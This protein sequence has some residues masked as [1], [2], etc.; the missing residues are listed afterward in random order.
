M[1]KLMLLYFAVLGFGNC[2]NAPA[3][4][5]P[6]AAVTTVIDTM[7][8]F[9]PYELD[10]P[11]QTL[12]LD[13]DL[14]EVSGLGMMPGDQQFVAVEDENGTIYTVDVVTGELLRKVDFHKA[15][16]YEGV[17]WVNGNVW[18]VKSTGTLYQVQ[19]FGTEAQQMVKHPN[20][21][22]RAYDVEGLGYD[23]ARHRLLLS[24]KG[25]GG[26]GVENIYRKSI[27]QFDL[28]TNTLDTVPAYSIELE[29]VQDYLNERPAIRKLTKLTE[30][31]SPG[32][33]EFGFCPSGL[34]VHPI[35]DELYILSSSGKLL[36]VVSK[37][38]AIRHIEKLDKDIHRQPEGICFS[39]E[40]TLY[41]SNEGKGSVEP[42]IHRFNFQERF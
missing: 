22:S 33:S 23:A 4:A 42:L 13:N 36:I 40:G 11:D 21:L 1:L 14:E 24:C 9:F 38:G 16:D 25:V 28:G 15:G 32:C 19:N 12:T 27:Y 29:A 20:F 31:F 18:V 35:T 37:E 17:E 26:D 2:Q 39:R 41:I 8:Y 34:A 3:D 10:D 5:P 7:N 6:T 30:F